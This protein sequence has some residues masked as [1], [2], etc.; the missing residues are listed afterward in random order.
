MRITATCKS[1]AIRLSS[2]AIARSW[3][4]AEMQIIYIYTSGRRMN[5]SI[6]GFGLGHLLSVEKIDVYGING[7]VMQSTIKRRRLE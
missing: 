4:V 7:A 6:I 2:A 1:I 3:N 5:S